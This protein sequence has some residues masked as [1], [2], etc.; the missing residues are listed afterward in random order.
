LKTTIIGRVAEYACDGD[1]DWAKE[2]LDGTG[3]SG[4][5]LYMETGEYTVTDEDGLYHFE[6]VTPGTHVVQVDEETLPQG[7]AAMMCEENSQY[8][9]L[10]TTA[11]A[12]PSA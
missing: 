4:V 8:A 3:V 2:I 7:Y 6:G 9:R 11:R 5:R 10:K 12:K 1:E